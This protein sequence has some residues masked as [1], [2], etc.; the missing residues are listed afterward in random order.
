MFTGLV[1]AVGRIATLEAR[2]RDL[3]LRIDTTLLPFEDLRLGESIAVSGVCLTVVDFD[4][5]GFAA[6]VSNETLALTT[7][8]A[9]A[10][11]A[12]VNLERALLPTTR[13]GGHLVA[14]HVDGLGQVESIA[15]DGR[16]QR[17]RFAAPAALLRYVAAKGSICVD[18][19]SLTVN[20]VDE[21]GFE[22]NLVPHT[23]ANTAF[24]AITTG[25][26]VNLEIDLIARYAERL[27]QG[28]N[29]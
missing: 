25:A 10:P 7:L 24:A 27:L 29:R 4:R 1:Q 8:G 17:W 9:L 28:M 26:A 20:A 6:D 21:A 5:D 15:D 16:S 23:I 22:V 13:L 3:R 19:V 2:G 11:G 14:G 18:G 12:P